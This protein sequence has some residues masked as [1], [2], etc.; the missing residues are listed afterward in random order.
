MNDHIKLGP[1]TLTIQV[2]DKQD[3]HIEDAVVVA[4]NSAETNSQH[5]REQVTIFCVAL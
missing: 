4:G 2:P 5:T 1:G 3:L